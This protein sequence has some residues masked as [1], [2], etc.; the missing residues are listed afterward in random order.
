MDPSFK[1]ILRQV[2]A[3]PGEYQGQPIIY[4]RDPLGFVEE[5]IALPQSVAYLLALMDG[6]RDLRDL[7]VE[8]TRVSGEI[9]PLEEII[10][11]VEFLNERGLLWSKKFEEVKERVYE[12]WFGLNIRPMAHANQAYPLDTEEARNFCERILNL[13]QKEVTIAPKILIAPHIDIEAGARAYAEAYKRLRIP[14]GSRIII[15][16]VG[17]YLDYPFSVLTKDL[18]TPFGILRVDRGG[19]LFLTKTKKLE[20]FPDHIAHKREHSLEFQALFIK[21]LLGDEVVVLPFLI[22]SYYI[23][24]E[25]EELLEDLVEGLSDLIDEKT[26]FVLGIDMCHRGLRYGDPFPADLSLAQYTLEKDKRMLELA[27]K[28][29]SKDLEKMIQEGEQLKNCGASALYVI[30][31]ILEKGGLRGRGEIFYQEALPFGKGSFVSVASAGYF[32]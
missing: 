4:L 27:F 31:K 20:L 10:K 11:L 23:L 16:G 25:N 9:V 26:Y 7:Q 5:L 6:K 2:D 28:G 8:A 19:L 18:A 24:K 3:F 29:E 30:S 1:P 32:L 17:H 15:L 14:S 13:V 12:K 21:Y 22:G